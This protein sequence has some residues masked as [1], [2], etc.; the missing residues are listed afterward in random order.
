M[1]A[2]EEEERSQGVVVACGTVPR[3]VE[4]EEVRNGS[5]NCCG[6]ELREVV[7]ERMTQQV[8]LRGVA[9][10]GALSAVAAAAVIAAPVGDGDDLKGRNWVPLDYTVLLSLHLRSVPVAN[11]RCWMLI[12]CWLVQLA[13]T[14]DRWRFPD[15]P[16]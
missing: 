9:R 11:L 14:K 7:S 15:S 4:E 3:R 5:Q 1:C 6:H 2:T 16:T 8:Q 13:K 10:A 12:R